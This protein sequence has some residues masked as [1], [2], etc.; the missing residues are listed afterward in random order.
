MIESDALA[1]NDRMDTFWKYWRNIDNDLGSSIGWVPSLRPVRVSA[2]INAS[3]VAVL[4]LLTLLQLSDCDDVLIVHT[5]I[6]Y[7]IGG[8]DNT[9]G[10]RPTTSLL[11]PHL[12]EIDISSCLLGSE[13]T[14]PR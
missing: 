13:G 14:H 7:Q 4:E 8:K 10:R 3:M 6:I 5:I 2:P 12:Y 1:Y 9:K 11:P